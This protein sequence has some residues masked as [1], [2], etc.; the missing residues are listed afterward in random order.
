VQSVEPADTKRSKE[1]IQ[2]YFLYQQSGMVKNMAD[3]DVDGRVQL[4]NI[5]T[6]A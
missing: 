4:N 6:I 2:I 5:V 1:K 3:Y